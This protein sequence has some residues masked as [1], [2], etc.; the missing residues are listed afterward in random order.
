MSDLFQIE[1]DRLEAEKR[2]QSHHAKRVAKL[3]KQQAV[4]YAQQYPLPLLL[5]AIEKF[6]R[7]GKR[8]LL[9]DERYYWTV[10]A[11][12]HLCW[13]IRTKRPDLSYTAIGGFLGK[14]HSTIVYAVQQ[15]NKRG[16]AHT[17]KVVNDIV[18]TMRHEA[19]II[20]STGIDPDTFASTS[21]EHRVSAAT[22]ENNSP[23][24]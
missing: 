14:D 1:I 4:Y 9:S 15:Y 24:T 6:Y 2:T 22:T 19:G 12:R 21:G 20:D 11:R 17:T 7:V 10:T 18:E 23:Q 16:S 5:D 13:L 8:E 3:R